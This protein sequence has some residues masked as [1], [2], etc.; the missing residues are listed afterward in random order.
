MEVTRKSA[1]KAW[2]RHL[3]LRQPARPLHRPPQVL[4]ADNDLTVRQSLKWLLEGEGYRVVTVANGAEALQKLRRGLKPC[5]ILLDLAMPVMDGYEF[6]NAQMQ[7]SRFAAIPLV[8][9]SAGKVSRRGALRGAA[10]L[11]KPFDAEALLEIVD[12]HCPRA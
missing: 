3:S 12:R 9:Y 8:V 1:K 5:L 4:V 11:Q 6:R 7:D 2:G 10:H